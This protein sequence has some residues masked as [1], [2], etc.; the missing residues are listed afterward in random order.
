GPREVLERRAQTHRERAA[1]NGGLADGGDLDLR[2][3]RQPPAEQLPG[4]GEEEGARRADPAAQNDELDAD[5]PAR[6]GGVER[7]S[8]GDLG[9][10]ELR[11]FVALARGLE[12]GP[13]LE[14][15]PQ[16]RL[17][18]TLCRLCRKLGDLRSRRVDVLLQR[19]ERE[20][21]LTREPMPPGVQLA[22][23]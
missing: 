10:H 15:R 2:R 5:E 7:D 13:R 1:E 11:R 6:P 16:A 8:P 21:D 18:L 23:E 3:E 12:Y 9:H 4:P 22:A 19:V 20:V 17:A 14:R